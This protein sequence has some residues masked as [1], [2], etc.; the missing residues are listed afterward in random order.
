MFDLYM[1]V[2]V[3]HFPRVSFDEP[4]LCHHNYVAEETHHG[5]ALLVT[6]KGA[7]RARGELGII[8]GSMGTQ[9]L[10]RARARQRRVV[11]LRLARRRARMMSRARRSGASA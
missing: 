6:R 8:P 7:I 10:H 5:E 9:S 1:E 4:V 11:P 3:R 2:I